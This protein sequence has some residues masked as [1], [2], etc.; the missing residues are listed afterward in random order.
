VRS[1]RRNWQ[2]CA[3]ATAARKSSV[4]VAIGARSLTCIIMHVTVEGSRGLVSIGK[5]EAVRMLEL[6]EVV[7]S[8]GDVAVDSY[9]RR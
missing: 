2:S 4:M 5:S 6:Q 1:L 3:A 9:C 7:T 8:Y